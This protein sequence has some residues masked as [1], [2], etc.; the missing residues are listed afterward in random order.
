M[1]NVSLQKKNTTY[2]KVDVFLFFL[3]LQH[4]EALKH[5]ASHIVSRKATFDLGYT[6][7]CLTAEHLNTRQVVFM[8]R[9]L[10]LLRST[11]KQQDFSNR[12]LWAN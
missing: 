9:G 3:L 7:L 11:L 12:S 1:T 5:S 10:Q 4:K 6:L 2:K 8:T